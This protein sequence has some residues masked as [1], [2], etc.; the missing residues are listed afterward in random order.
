VGLALSR[1]RR[2]HGA[3]DRPVLRHVHQNARAPR[4][5]I[6]AGTFMALAGGTASRS[7]TAT[8]VGRR[9]TS[10]TRRDEPAPLPQA[11]A[12]D[13]GPPCTAA[14]CAWEPL[15]V[16]EEA[17]AVR[18]FDFPSRQCLLPLCRRRLLR[19]L[20]KRAGRRGRAAPK[21][22]LVREVPL[23][24]GLVIQLTNGNASEQPR[25]DDQHGGADLALEHRAAT[26]LA[27]AHD[28]A[29]HRLHLDTSTD[30]I[31]GRVARRTAQLWHGLRLG[32]AWSRPSKDSPDDRR[33]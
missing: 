29:T 33:S 23:D 16:A 32:R 28:L 17:S 18:T 31:G 20:T 27:L 2:R 15:I 10:G 13:S 4:W 7:T 22:L 26:V 6:P 19:P 24:A 21:V 9:C 1:A 30:Q 14:V 25:P 8:T 3:L 12:K 11:D 5:R